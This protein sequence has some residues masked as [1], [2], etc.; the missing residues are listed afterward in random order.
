MFVSNAKYLNNMFNFYMLFGL[1][2]CYL[3]LS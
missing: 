2:F 3:S 1:Q